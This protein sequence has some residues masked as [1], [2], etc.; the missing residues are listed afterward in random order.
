MDFRSEERINELKP[1]Y[2]YA[3]IDGR[4]NDIFYIGKGC[5]DRVYQHEKEVIRGNV[6]SLKQKK[7]KEI[8]IDGA[9]VKKLIIGR[10]DTED[11]A[12]AVESTLIHWVYGVDNLTN[13]QSGH[14]VNAIR[15]K[16]NMSFLQGIDE[17]ELNYC[18]REKEK[19]D[20]NDI[21][22]YLRDLQEFIETNCDIKFDT[23]D[24]K[25]DRHTYLVKYMKGVRFAVS[26]HHTA[27]RSATVTIE[28]LDTK[29]HNKE[30]VREICD[31]TLLEYKD[32]GR[33]GRLMPAKHFTDKHEILEMVKR[34]LAEIGKA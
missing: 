27:R 23:I 26:C 25:N 28:S 30:C 31:R 32:N 15:P 1:F 10:F 19:R 21:K 12:F 24:T 3:L 17:P 29:A 8:H 13:D 20:R 2:V 22:A 9:E 4:I 14:G 34:T 11:E 5:E 18:E 7:I 6:E 33:Y 16:G